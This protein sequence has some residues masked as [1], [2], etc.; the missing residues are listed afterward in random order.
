MNPNLPLIK[1]LREET[2]AGVQDC[3]LA[4][5]QADFVYEAAL[6]AIR[7]KAAAE[8][9]KRADRRA[10]QGVVE[11]YSHGNGRIGVMVEVNAETD[12]AGRS[13]AFRAFAHEVALQIAAAAPEYVSDE[14]I[15]QHILAEEIAQATAKAQAD[16]K[17]AAIIPTIVQGRLEKFKNQ[18]VLLRQAYIRDE[19]TS[20]ADLLHQ[21]AAGVGEK[22]VIRRF[23]RWEI[24]ASAEEPA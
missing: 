11:L 5:E 19:K 6:K 21:T 15:P 4:L 17:P 3:R 10:V 18:R 13:P 12:F 23:A 24:D 20:I 14:E 1:K 22:V 2:G 9:Q 7:A 16:G 8:A